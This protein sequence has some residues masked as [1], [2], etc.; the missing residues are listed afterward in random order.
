M[1]IGV[2]LA[3][4]LID[5]C[6]HAGISRVE[7]RR[8]VAGATS[9]DAAARADALQY[10][11]GDGPCLET[12]HDRTT[13]LSQDLAHDVR[14]P[15]WVTRVG[16]ELGLGS[17]LSLL[18]FTHARSYGALNLFADHPHAFDADDIA[19]AESLAAHLAVAMASGQEI[20]HRGNAMAGRTVIGQAEGILMERLDLDAGQAFD[21][22]RRISQD[23]NRKLVAV[24]AEIVATR[25]LPMT[26]TGRAANLFN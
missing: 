6:D 26:E 22:L 9:D 24:A 21:Y 25:E 16:S 18:L 4:E 11:L 7:G 14:W 20:V 15:T 2:A 13:T 5:G 8:I 12:I 17:S 10:E 19:V 23:G 3:V 1:Q